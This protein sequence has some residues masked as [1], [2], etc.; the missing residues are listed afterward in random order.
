MELN[1]QLTYPVTVS[2]FGVVPCCS[3]AWAHKIIFLDE[4]LDKLETGMN[5]YVM[6]Q[7]NCLSSIKKH[8]AKSS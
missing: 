4:S 3:L 1:C 2:L 5:S 8:K 6:K 7:S